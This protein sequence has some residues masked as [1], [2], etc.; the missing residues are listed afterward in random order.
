M[1]EKVNNMKNGYLCEVGKWEEIF[2]KLYEEG[3][4]RI[5]ALIDKIGYTG[6]QARYYEIAFLS[7][8]YQKDNGKWLVKSLQSA[9]MSQNDLLGRFIYRPTY[10]NLLRILSSHKLDCNSIKTQIMLDMYEV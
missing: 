7:R 5:S 2:E 8:F 4:N 9:F 1:K 10:K 3:Q 6:V